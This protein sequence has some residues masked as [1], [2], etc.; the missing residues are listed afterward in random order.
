MTTS[1]TDDRGRL[2]IPA[3]L[4][5]LAGRVSWP[6]A[7]TVVLVIALLALAGER[8]LA[9]RDQS[10]QVRDHEAVIAA[11]EA[12]VE[13]L[14]GISAS[15]SAADLDALLAGATASFRD[16]LEAQADRL[17]TTLRSNRVAATGEVVATGVTHLGGDRATVIVAAV[18]SV[19]NKS[20]SDAE[21]RTYRLRVDLE[22]SG[23][24]WLVAGLEFVA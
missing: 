18:G 14:I 3:R 17:R 21:P 1:A 20:T 12:E 8:S 7:A 15:T 10:Q 22:R 13:G 6:V 16:E 19:K 23:S 2:A 24:K 4:S 5:G 11:A 9:W